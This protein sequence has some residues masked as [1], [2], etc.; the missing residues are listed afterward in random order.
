MIN[1]NKIYPPNWIL[2]KVLCGDNSDSIPPIARGLGQK[3]AVKL[4]PFLGETHQHTV[5]DVV[6]HCELNKGTGK[7]YQAILDNKDKL[8]VYWKV[9]QLGSIE[10]SLAGLESMVESLNSKPIFK[11]FQLRL[12]FMQDNSFKQIHQFATWSRLLMPLNAASNLK[13]CNGKTD[14]GNNANTATNTNENVGNDKGPAQDSD[15]T[16]QKN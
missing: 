3:T 1:D 16:Q 9:M 2:L 15:C 10:L 5:K 14:N 4:F 13:E 8:D 11:P 7:M 6:E 12:M